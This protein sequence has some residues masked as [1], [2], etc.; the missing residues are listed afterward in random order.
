MTFTADEI[1]AEKD[2]QESLTAQN[3]ITHYENM[4][5][6]LYMYWNYPVMT[7]E[8]RKGLADTWKGHF[9]TLQKIVVTG[10]VFPSA[11][12]P[13]WIS[14]LQAVG[15]ANTINMSQTV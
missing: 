14:C 9:S 11:F 4:L 10:D 7:A 15:A 13:L 6:A 1:Q 3:Q 12:D 5:I 2:K 8:Q